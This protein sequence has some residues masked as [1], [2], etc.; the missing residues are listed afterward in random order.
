MIS[1]DEII[2]AIA[3]IRPEGRILRRFLTMYPDARRRTRIL[4]EIEASR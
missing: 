1:D 2:A 3:E 4:G